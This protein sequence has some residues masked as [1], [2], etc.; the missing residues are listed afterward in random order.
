MVIETVRRGAAAVANFAMA[1]ITP[2]PS[3]KIK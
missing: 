3:V 1:V 2:E